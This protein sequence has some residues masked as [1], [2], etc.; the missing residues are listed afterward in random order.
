MALWFLQVIEVFVLQQQQ[1]VQKLQ[2]DSDV[3]RIFVLVIDQQT[4]LHFD[5]YNE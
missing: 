4:L 1:Q 3:D 5:Y 2:F